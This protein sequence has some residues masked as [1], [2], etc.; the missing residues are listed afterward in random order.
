MRLG[1]LDALKD[2]FK[3]RLADCNEWIEKAKDYET[4]IRASA[5][6]AFIAE[7]IMTIDNAPTV[8]QINI[9]CEKA[10]ETSID[11]MKA[12]LQNVLDRER[13]KGEWLEDKVAFHF[14]CNQC[15]CAL[16]QLK[17]EVFEGD[18]DYNFCP[19]CGAGMKSEV[20]EE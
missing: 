2:D 16:R 14:V 6:K 20:E 4:K 15:G 5:V 3:S 17:S 10:D 13:Q 9:F 18:Y 12:E 7:V 8:P 19:N 1:D 11:D